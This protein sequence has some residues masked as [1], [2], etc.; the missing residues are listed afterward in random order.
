MR[1]SDWSADVCSSD[2]II[3]REPGE[4]GLRI[5]ERAGR[6]GDDVPDEE[7][8][9]ALR[10]KSRARAV[11]RTLGISV[12][13]GAGFGKLALHIGEI[14]IGGAQLDLKR[15]IDGPIDAQLSAEYPFVA[16]RDLGDVLVGKAADRK[17][18][19]LNSSH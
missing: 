4:W 12:I 3:E 7:Q 17:S 6:V 16:I 15:V 14:I 9:I 5:I 19:R 11:G 8:A 10:Q 18:T 2:L 13:E 1:I